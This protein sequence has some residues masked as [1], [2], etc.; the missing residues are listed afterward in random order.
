MSLPPNASEA[1]D[2]ISAGEVDAVVVYEPDGPRLSHLEGP[3]EPFR[4]LV[5]HIQEGALS[6]KSDGRISYCNGH[7]ARLLATSPENLVGAPLG[8]FVELEPSAFHALVERGLR[9]ATRAEVALRTPSGAVPVQ[10]TLGPLAR[11]TCC[12]VVFDLRERKRGEEAA[13]ATLAAHD[14]RQ[15]FR[16]L[17]ESIS[18]YAIYFIDP[19]GRVAAWTAGAQSMTGHT[20]ADVIGQS[21]TLF[22]PGDAMERGEP[23]G[24]LRTA[25]ETG[26]AESEGWRVRKDGSR[27]WAYAVI[28]RIE[29]GSGQLAGYAEVTRDMTTQR[30]LE[31]QLRQSQKM[32]AVG[33]LAGGVAHDFNN[34]LSVLLGHALMILEDLDADDPI[35]ADIEEMKVAAFRAADLT[36]QLLAFSRQQVVEPRLLDLNAS[37]ASLDRMLRRLL[38]VDVDLCVIPA[39]G[40]LTIRADPT[41]IEQI[42]MNLAVNARDAMPRGGTLTIETESVEFDAESARRGIDLTPGSYVLLRVI[43]TGIGMDATVQARIFEPFFTTKDKGKGTGLGLATVFGIVKQWGGH[44]WVESEPGRGTTFEI[45]WPR[46]VGA[47]SVIRPSAPPPA[48]ARQKGGETILLVEDDA[49]VRTM[50]R[51]ILRRSGYAVLEAA[52][53]GEAL[54]LCEQHVEPIDLLLTDVVLPLMNGRQLAVRLSE[55]RPNMRVLYMSGYTDDVFRKDLLESGITVLQKPLT[56]VGLTL[57]VQEMLA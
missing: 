38:G 46:A 1:L 9:E 54:L 57:K 39:I 42:I 25:S 35:R 53:G 48:L 8:R 55:I 16:L 27:F 4:T 13:A 49:Q 11:A 5:E 19:Q 51:N 21:I 29:D 20:E 10:L 26:R 17:V 6:V 15:R 56:P 14:L 24:A 32:D 33:R 43:D 52:N 12:V 18:D 28:T 50:T 2:A 37:L 47:V 44:V 40:T 23:E 22:Y 36:R 31:Q 45:C 34:I 7:F 3:D 41:H 30:A